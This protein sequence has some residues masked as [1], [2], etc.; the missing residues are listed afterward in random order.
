MKRSM[1]SSAA[2]AHVYEKFHEIGIKGVN[3]KLEVD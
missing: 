2:V 3:R 1:R